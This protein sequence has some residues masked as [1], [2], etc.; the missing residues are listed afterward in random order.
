MKKKIIII[1]IAIIIVAIAILVKV[2]V[3]YDKY[4]MPNGAEINIANETIDVYDE[5]NLYDLIES[6]NVKIISDDIEIDTSEIGEYTYTIEYKYKLRKYFYEIN[7]S[8][9]DTV[10]PVFISAPNSKTFY[11]SESGEEDLTSK[12]TYADNYD[13]TPN[14]EIEGEVNFDEVGTYQ[15]SY[16]ITDQSENETIKDTVIYIIERP[17]ETTEEEE[18]DEE[19]T[20]EEE[21]EEDSNYIQYQIEN[22]KTDDTMIGIDVSK[23]QGDIDF[24]A[25]KNAGVEFVIIRMGVMQDKDAEMTIDSMFTENYENAKSAGLKVGAYIYSESTTVES[26]ISNAQ[27]VIDTL[28]GGELDFPV[29]FDW[30][31]WTNF[32]DMG[33]NLHRLNEMYDAFSETLEEAGYSAM[34]YASEY[35]LNYTWLTL[36]DYDIWV[37]KYSENE[38]EI[39]G[40]NYIL[41]QNSNTGKVDGIDGDVDLDIYYIETEN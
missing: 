30:E 9:V 24:E 6:S 39:E 16:I 34:L 27:F 21:E 20:E 40:S 15:I 18:T 5:I 32:N 4:E 36:K 14:L 12:I 8:V 2:F 11:V 3:F 25:V 35:Y 13:I 17:T 26:A 41:W 1:S 38:P 23:W 29:C 33:I 22:Y 7:Y 31:S 19:E 37:A 10:A 28:N